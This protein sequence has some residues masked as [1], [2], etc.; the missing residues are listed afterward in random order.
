MLTFGYA[1]LLV[2][3]LI[4]LAVG[5]LAYLNPINPSPAWA[6]YAFAAGGGFLPFSIGGLVYRLLQRLL[7]VAVLSAAAAL[8]I[9]HPM[10]A[11]AADGTA[12]DLPWGDLLSDLVYVVGT[13]AIAFV[14]KKLHSLLD[15]KIGKE[16]TDR[17]EQLLEKA[18]NFGINQTS[19]AVAGKALTVDVGNAVLAQAVNYAVSQAPTLTKWAGGRDAI[20]NKVIA[21]LKL[22]PEAGS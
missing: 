3:S 7:M 1:G 8:F 20:A 2:L 21:R 11:F 9:V 6:N 22:A 4:C 13:V 18:I 5:L 16:Q 15:A 12:I 14:A 10:P 17:V 19:G